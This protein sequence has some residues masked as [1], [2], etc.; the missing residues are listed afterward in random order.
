M[1]FRDDELNIFKNTDWADYRL[2]REI[3]IKMVFATDMAHHNNNLNILR[4]IID[5]LEINQ[6]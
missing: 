4:N 6:R 1:L 2:I 5:K 3:I